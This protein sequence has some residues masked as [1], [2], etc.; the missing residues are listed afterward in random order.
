MDIHE[1]IYSYWYPC[2][3][4]VLRTRSTSDI[5]HTEGYPDSHKNPW[6]FIVHLDMPIPFTQQPPVEKAF[7][8]ENILSSYERRT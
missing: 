3:L 1:S 8:E 7:Y 5:M 2:K 4:E 6:I